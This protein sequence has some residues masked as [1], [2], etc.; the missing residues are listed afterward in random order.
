MSGDETFRLV[1]VKDL[2]VGDFIDLEG[3]RNLGHH[4]SVEFEYSKVCEIINET[5]D[6]IVVAFDD[7]M[8][9]GYGPEELMKVVV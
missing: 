6:C 3:D 4:I 2:K 1:K 7:G 8:T 9:A 5:D